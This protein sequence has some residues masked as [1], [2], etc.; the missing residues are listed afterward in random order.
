MVYK[1]YFNSVKLEGG[2]WFFSVKVLTKNY[3][4]KFTHTFLSLK[5]HSFSLFTF[6]YVI[7]KKKS[8][9]INLS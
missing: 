1:N 2:V 5:C 7:F 6:F 3:T 4:Y 9:F 8:V